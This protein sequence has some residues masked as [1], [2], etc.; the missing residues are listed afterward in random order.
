MPQHLDHSAAE[1]ATEGPNAPLMTNPNERILLLVTASHASASLLAR[2]LPECRTIVAQDLQQA[3]EAAKHARPDL[4][5]IDTVSI[6]LNAQ[7]L[8]QMTTQCGLPNV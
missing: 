2:Y 5:A 8:Q 4:I 3:I 6:E 7:E 1:Y